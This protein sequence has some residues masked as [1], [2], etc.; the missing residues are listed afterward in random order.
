[1][2]I[3]SLRIEKRRIRHQRVIAG[4][5][6][7]AR[8]SAALVLREGDRLLGAALVETTVARP[9][10]T[11]EGRAAL[12]HLLSRDFLDLDGQ[13]AWLRDW[14][15]LAQ[16]DPS[17]RDEANRAMAMAGLRLREDGALAVGSPASVPTLGVW[18]ESTPWAGSQLLAALDALPGASRA[19]MTFG[20]VRSRATVIPAS[21]VPA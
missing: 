17:R 4:S 2:Q 5:E 16:D 1:M 6:A 13:A 9:V 10:D 14:L 12:E 19:S 15:R 18:F 3:W 20:G 8:R 21:E 11:E 7:E